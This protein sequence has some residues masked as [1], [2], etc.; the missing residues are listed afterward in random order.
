MKAVAAAHAAAVANTSIKTSAKGASQL[1]KKYW[2]NDVQVEMLPPEGSSSG[3]EDYYDRHEEKEYA[4]P[5]RIQVLEKINKH[6]VA[7]S[8]SSMQPIRVVPSLTTMRMFTSES[9]KRPKLETPDNPSEPVVEEYYDEEEEE[10][11]SG[12]CVKFLWVFLKLQR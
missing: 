9:T 3:E 2:I 5:E 11:E 4:Q 1:P 6:K 8:K 12:N 10:D 7:N